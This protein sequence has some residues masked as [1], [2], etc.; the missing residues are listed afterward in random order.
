[1]PLTPLVPVD[2]VC[3]SACGTG[4]ARVRH[5]GGT[6]VREVIDEA[7]WPG[8]L[9][10]RPYAR[11]MRLSPEGARVIGAL[12]EKELTTPDQY[13]LTIKSLL[14]ACNQ[15]S[16]R[17]PVVTYDEH[18]VMSTL[19]ALKEQRLVRFVLPSHGRS[20]VRY[21]HVLPEVLALDQRQC[22]LVAVLL[23]RG[24]QTVGELRSRT[25]RMTDFG[26]LDE[27]EHELHFLS[28]VEEPLASSLGR[29][30][31]QK[32]ERW[33]CPAVTSPDA[34]PHVPPDGISTH[35]EVSEASTAPSSTGNAFP[36]IDP[37]I[38]DQ[39]IPENLA[40]ELRAE[41]AELRSEVGAL[42]RDL[43]A[44]RESLGD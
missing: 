13:P 25:E 16:N 35:S 15:A 24:P 22:A 5:V 32:E 8:P 19:D 9:P 6:W 12:V 18:N 17:D 23:L 2:P 41:L 44:L 29:R 14:A 4:P 33:I 38:D 3:Q 28:K 30:P 42:R 43:H 11:P 1:M 36:A 31:G 37:T 10:A 21:R 27:V 20:A 40:D 26:G 7:G 39:R 34:Q